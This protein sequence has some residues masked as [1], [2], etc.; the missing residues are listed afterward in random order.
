MWKL[1]EL[2]AE[3]HG[4]GGGADGGRHLLS[5]HLLGAC[6]RRTAAAAGAGAS[7]AE[8]GTGTAAAAA[9]GGGSSS[10]AGGAP[11][12]QLPPSFCFSIEPTKGEGWINRTSLNLH[13]GCVG[14]A[15]AQGC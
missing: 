8:A 3:L 13:V 14:R 1:A 6:P 5:R 9:A 4:L 12:S 15:T 11:K 7:A 10:A 2:L